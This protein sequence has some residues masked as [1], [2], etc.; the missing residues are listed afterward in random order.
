MGDLD[1]EDRDFVK[2]IMSRYPTISE[3]FFELC[4]K[5]SPHNQGYWYFHLRHCFTEGEYPW[6]MREYETYFKKDLEVSFEILD[7]IEGYIIN[8]TLISEGAEY[9]WKMIPMEGVIFPS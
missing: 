8:S 9:R 3:R 5:F 2:D 4:E 6:I 7:L 1:K